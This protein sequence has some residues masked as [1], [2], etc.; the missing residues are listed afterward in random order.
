[1]RKLEQVG[2]TYVVCRE[3]QVYYYP[4]ENYAAIDMDIPYTVDHQE[5]MDDFTTLKFSGW[6]INTAT[7]RTWDA[8]LVETETGVYSAKTMKRP[9]VA[10]VLGSDDFLQSGYEMQI[11]LNA[12]QNASVLFIDQEN[13]ICYRTNL[14]IGED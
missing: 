14:V 13:Q 3:Y 5:T 6:S 7:G 10:K 1:M 9:D 2:Y 11:P 8:I 4:W 12:V